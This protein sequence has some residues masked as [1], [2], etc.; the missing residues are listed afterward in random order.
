M[1]KYFRYRQ[2]V[3]GKKGRYPSRGDVNL[4]A[5]ALGIFLLQLTFTASSSAQ[6]LVFKGQAIGW[7]VVSQMEELT[8]PS[9]SETATK[10]WRGQAG[11]RYLPE[12]Q[13]TK[14]VKENYSFDAEFSANI[15]GSG[16]YWSSDSVIWDGKV[17]PY[18]AWVKFSGDQFELRAG[19]QKI[20]FGSANMLR[21]LMWFDQIDP[22]D[23]LQLTDGVYSILGRYYFLNNANI[24][25]WGLYGNDKLKGWEFIPSV[26]N[27][28]EFGFRVQVPVAGGELATTYHY[29]VADVEEVMQIPHGE[30]RYAREKRLALDGKFDYLLGLWF[31][32]TLIHQEIHIPE[33]TWR[34]ALNLGADYTFGL[35]NGLNIMAE[36][37]TMGSSDSPFGAGEDV[38]FTALSANYPFSIINNLNGIIF[39]DWSNKEFYN[40]INWSWQ[41]DKWTF[42]IMGFWNPQRFNLYQGLEG[43]NLYAGRGLQFMIVFNH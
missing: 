43:A 33:I 21:P 16:L 1:R 36:A 13:F 2:G 29:R 22:R 4:Y 39:Y 41:F 34:R 28:P 27:K 24:W 25:V 20:N 31:E 35:G 11:M 3:P 10:V 7:G 26:R 23:P 14:P 38:Y 15:Y 8:G 6:S 12:L 37:F 40:F 42:F 5:T 17:K 19:L 18:R 9:G 32:A 30:N